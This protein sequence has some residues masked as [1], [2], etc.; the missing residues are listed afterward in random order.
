MIR[1]NIQKIKKY[2]NEPNFMKSFD[3]TDKKITEKIQMEIQ[4]MSLDDALSF[5][6]ECGHREGLEETLKDDKKRMLEIIEEVI[7]E[8]NQVSD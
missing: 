1:T 2:E 6:Y 4:S 7:K 8:R 5:C 3:S